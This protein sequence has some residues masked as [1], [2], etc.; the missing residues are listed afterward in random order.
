L[1][2]RSFIKVLVVDDFEPW[3][4][5][6]SST[7]Q[8]QPGLEVIGEASDGL[9]A[10]QKAQELQPDLILL[11][12][13][14]PRLNGIEAA[15]QIREKAPSTKILFCSENHSW[16]IAEEGIR[17]AAGYVLKSE[18]GRDLLPA[19]EAVLQGKQFL[20]S[21]FAR[22]N[23]G[24]DKEHVLDRH[25]AKRR[26]AP[27]PPRNVAMRH[28][29]MFYPDDAALVSAFGRVIKAVLSAG[30]TS[31]VVATGSHRAEIISSLKA[32]HVDVD[33]AREQ[34]RFIAQDADA[35]LAAIMV[36]DMP[37]KIRCAELLAN[38][39]AT[40]KGA[41]KEPIRIAICG[42]CAPILL[43]R[44]NAE[45]AIRLEHLWNEVT[46]KHGA[47]TL[48]GYV[49]STFPQRENST[50]FQKICAEHSAVQGQELGYST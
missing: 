47:D 22:Q 31:I 19:V 23:P 2:T 3:R 32:D 9:E 7:L 39:I 10:V 12:I 41:Q 29:A 42:E 20:S 4:R 36:N 35:T 33:G 8:A 45:G 11:D 34:K 5:F 17:I 28:E 13:G 25:S 14:L 38:L 44:G 30:N 24:A 40:A 43:A 6:A 37:D 18:A 15:R 26:V 49:W 1:L 16:D 46:M 21:I 50:E 48:C 27:L